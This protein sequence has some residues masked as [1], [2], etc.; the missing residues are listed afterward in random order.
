MGRDVWIFWNFSITLKLRK[1]HILRVALSRF[2][3]EDAA[4]NYLEDPYVDVLQVV[5]GCNDAQ[6]FCTSYASFEW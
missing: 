3:K 2:R 1:I 4:I 6:S 5:N